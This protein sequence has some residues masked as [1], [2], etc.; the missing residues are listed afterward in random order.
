V[1][2]QRNQ[3][4]GDNY[5]RFG[6]PYSAV[7][8]QINTFMGQPVGV[9]DFQNHP[10]SAGGFQPYMDQYTHIG[11]IANQLYV[12]PLSANAANSD[13]E[14]YFSIS[15]LCHDLYL[16]S[17]MDSQGFV[18]LSVIA[19]FNRIKDL[20]SSLDQL[21]LVCQQSQ[22]LEWRLGV[23]GKDRIRKREGWDKW[24]LDK[25]KRDA[26]A[27][28]DGVEAASPAP[29]IPETFVPVR[30]SSLPNSL[31]PH[32]S[33]AAVMLPMNGSGYP[34]D[35]LRSP[36]GEDFSRYQTSPPTNAPFVAGNMDHSQAVKAP[37]YVAT[38]SPPGGANDFSD[39][40]VENLVVMVRSGQNGL[41]NGKVNEPNGV[42]STSG[43]APSHE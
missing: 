22:S 26:S 19:N 18:L 15:N 7:L 35:V 38:T 25:A 33:P 4:P 13:S 29:P 16:R 32:M 40:Q 39:A 10:A 41:P 36:T 12:L 23:D 43:V 24:V 14:Y 20:N 11:M 2:G 8:P 28:H 34:P 3:I 17:H 6:A 42:G 30:H 37:G 1:R 31:S 21:K 9:F 5:G 27:Q